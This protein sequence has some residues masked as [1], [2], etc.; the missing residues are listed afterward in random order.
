M[1]LIRSFLLILAMVFTVMVAAEAAD[2]VIRVDAGAEGPVLHGA[3][4]LAADLES[5]K[6]STEISSTK[7]AA[8]KFTIYL[9]T[10]DSDWAPEAEAAAGQIPCAREKAES[11]AVSVYRDAAVPVAIAVGS[12]GVGAMYGAYEFAEQVRRVPLGA[13]VFS[14]MTSTARDPFLELR[15]VNPFLHLQAFEDQESWYYDEEFWTTYLDLLS[16]SRYNLLDFHAM[17][18]IESTW[19]PN[20]FLYLL[21]SDKYPQVGVSA[22]QADKNLRM[23]NRIIAMAKERGIHVS[24]MSYHASWHLSR[25]EKNP[26]PEPSEEQLT[27]YTREMVAKLITKCPDLWMVGFRIGESGMEDESF[28]LKSYIAGIDDAGRDINLFTRTWGAEYENIKMLGEKFPG[29]FYIEIKYNG[30]QLGLPYPAITDTFNTNAGYSWEKYFS[31]PRYYK[32]IWQIRP[33]GTHRL[34]RWGDPGFASRA[35]RVSAFQGAVG[36]TMETMTSYYPMTDYVFKPGGKITYRWDHDKN[37]FWY[38]VWGRSGYDPDIPEETFIEMFRQRYG[39]QAGPVIY[40][41]MLDASKLIPWIYSWR[42]IGY[43]HRQMAPAYEFGGTLLDFIARPPKYGHGSFVNKKT[44]MDTLDPNA[45]STIYEFVDSSLSTKKKYYHGAEM[46]PLEVADLLDEYADKT[47]ADLK[48]A[49]GIKKKEEMEFLGMEA[50]F[51]VAVHMAR[52]YAEKIRAATSFEFFGQTGSWYDLMD[53]QEKMNLAAGHWKKLAQH[54]KKYFRP[55]IDT[56]RMHTMEFTWEEEGKKLDQD[57]EIIAV[58]KEEYLAKVK[59]AK[60]PEILHHNAARVDAGKKLELRCNVLA[61]KGN[62]KLVLNFVHEAGGKP[63]TKNFSRIPRTS[64]GWSMTVPADWL[65]TGEAKYF[66]ELKRGGKTVARYPESGAVGMLIRGENNPPDIFVEAMRV[67]DGKYLIYANI[68]DESGVDRVKLFYKPLPTNS[69]WNSKMM[70]YIG[71]TS[72][73]A[74]LPK[75]PEGWIYYMQAADVYGNSSMAPDFRQQ[76][77]YIAIPAYDPAEE[78]PVS[79]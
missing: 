59:S 11:Y 74:E 24:L 55:I 66:I 1:H 48:E 72:Y 69:D 23:F 70:E 6:L 39:Q 52:Y 7:S 5:K 40:R 14:Y 12:D 71:G 13:D 64:T 41:A 49:K 35:S 42:C 37:W 4:V 30:E 73:M 51:M 57:F 9:G 10:K 54:G 68:Q 29:K 33:N 79:E 26:L 21:K 61:L 16:W 2:V 56:L 60:E 50:E 46:G 38:V 76:A 27:E 77:S 45:L 17:Y 20:C 63:M 75:V 44:Y 43:D 78:K 47:V 58:A 18:N 31:Q 28:Y 34:I 19:F 36:F 32:V 8:G 67:K 22:E 3:K 25:N 62:E 65:K 15:A 53:A